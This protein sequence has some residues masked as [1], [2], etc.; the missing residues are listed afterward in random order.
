MGHRFLRKILNHLERVRT[1]GHL[2]R[3]VM[4]R[5]W[6]KCRRRLLVAALCTGSAEICGA[7]Q[8]ACVF[9]PASWRPSEPQSSPG[10]DQG[11][12]REVKPPRKPSEQG[13]RLALL[14]GISILPWA[15]YSYQT[16]VIL[17]N[18][19]QLQYAGGQGSPGITVF[20][21]PAV[22]LPGALRR[23][24]VGV[25]LGAGGFD[26][27]N[28]SV[29]PGDI[30]TPFLKQNLQDAL[31]DQHSLGQGWH[32]YFSPYVEHTVRSFS[33][34]RLSV[35]YQYARQ[36][37]SYS[38]TFFPSSVS[39]ITASYEIQLRYTSHLFRFSFNNYLYIDDSD[40]NNNASQRSSR[41]TGLIRQMGLLAGT[42]K[43]I[44]VF[45]G[46]GPIW[47]F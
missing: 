27:V 23:L 15:D 17:P 43:T 14:L 9:S 30:P 3:E 8:T 32:P 4:V 13:F 6:G 18:G 33:G 36:T 20:A 24:T 10:P 34:N 35:G 31:K 11:Q 29:V 21:G 12:P 19:Q 39:P 40:R 7:W 26:S 47:V 25:N 5:Y 45:F 37:G 22:T 2:S 16:T 1:I 42:N 44:V 38:G 28:R 41:K 46:I